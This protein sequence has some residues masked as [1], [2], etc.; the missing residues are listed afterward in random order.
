MI[1]PCLHLVRQSRETSRYEITYDEA[2]FN[3]SLMNGERTVDKDPLNNFINS[4]ER[5]KK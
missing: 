3:D 1:T 4:I 2:L 5:N